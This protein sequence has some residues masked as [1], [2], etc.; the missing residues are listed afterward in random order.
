MALA[1][2]CVQ[3]QLSNETAGENVEYGVEGDGMPA[4][5]CRPRSFRSIAFSEP[6]P[7]SPDSGKPSRTCNDVTFDDE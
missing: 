2:S 6:A 5:F 1:K 3:G 7:V 4:T